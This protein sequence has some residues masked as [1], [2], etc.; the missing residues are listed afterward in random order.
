MMDRLYMD[1]TIAVMVKGNKLDVPRR[2]DPPSFYTAKGNAHLQQ[3]SLQPW[4]QSEIAIALH[5]AGGL[6]CT[7]ALVLLCLSLGLALPFQPSC[8]IAQPVT[9]AAVNEAIDRGVDYLRQ[10][11]A[12]QEGKWPG[13]ADYGCGES[14]LVLLAL[15]NCG[16]S[17]D[18]PT[19][20]SGLDYLARTNPD[21]T[22]EV[23]LQTMVF[24]AANPQAYVRQIRRNVDWLQKAQSKN[25]REKGGWGYT[26]MGGGTDPSNAQFGV[27]ALWEA[28]RTQLTKSVEP[29]RLAAE[30]WR[31]RQNDHPRDGDRGAWSYGNNDR[32]TGSMTC[33]GIASLIM[34]ED[35]LEVL[36]VNIRGDKLE[37]CLGERRES[38]SDLGLRWLERNYEI[39]RNPN[40]D[41]W[42]FYYLYALERVG[43]LTGERFI[44]KHDWYREGCELLVRRQDPLRGFIAEGGNI[45]NRVADTAL[46]LLFLSK[47][48]RKVVIG[49]LMLDSPNSTTGPR[50]AIQHLTGHIEDA[51]KKELA[52]QSIALKP[53]TLEQLLEA[54]ILFMSGTEA[55]QID[56]RSKKMLKEYV[57]QGG[58]LFAE[59]RNGDGCNGEAF[60]NSFRKL[61]EELF[62][63]P[64]EKMSP[65]HPVWYAEAPANVANL[66]KDFWLY[67]LETCCRTSVVYSP[68]SLSC[69]WE[70]HRPHG[71]A[72][73]S[74]PQK[75]QLECE[76]ASIVGVN[77]ATYA[78]GR[79]LKEKL[80]AVEIIRTV[81]SAQPV[82]RGILRVPRLQ[83]SGGAE[84]TPRSVP[85][86]M[87][88]FR[89][90]LS[91]QVVV[92]SPI[93]SI[94][95]K[96]LEE[97]QV[98]YLS[99][100][101]KFLFSEQEKADLREYFQNG[102]VLIGDAVCG[103]Q[104]FADAARAQLN[105]LLPGSVWKKVP[106]DHRIL[107]NEF[108]GFDIRRVSIID[109]GA[110]GRGQAVQVQKHEGS[111]V[112]EMLMFNDRS[113]AIFSP[114]DLSCALESRQSTQC[115]GYPRA[116]AA[117]IGI[118]MLLYSLLN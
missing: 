7:R 110:G 47:G 70:V 68:I 42:W 93:I 18:D 35:S 91:S 22:Y 82:T 118:N 26:A 101:R 43:R 60:D 69:R 15:L 63:K 105:E 23:A 66:P 11:Q 92:D 17:I 39:A 95:R 96:A 28:Q 83:H 73:E 97:S 115:R 16:L 10:T 14:A 84:D 87:E 13:Y 106:S 104:E 59:A 44:A 61:M 116:D 72:F 67:G 5:K 40:G 108:R 117:K 114:L 45:S 6:T 65:E 49:K 1:G 31:I 71:I 19:V 4:P 64:L 107:T 58:F 81:K 57:E 32:F 53:A 112:L 100:R 62:E 94:D 56:E 37:C 41:A 50:H 3:T 24:C 36:D 75:L 113:V 48:K 34:A 9:S 88:V 20:A 86:L 25:G 33:A 111:P 78:T 76:E 8:G 51:W 85:N 54:P 38:L 21:K 80:D 2:L 77:I 30:Y 99:G 102:G 55:I 109:P 46:A 98:V 12:A 103:S 74:L 52:W 90:E 89:R 29:M 27:L 79:E